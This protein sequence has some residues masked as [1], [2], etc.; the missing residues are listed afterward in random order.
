MFVSMSLLAAV[1]LFPLY[2]YCCYVVMSFRRIGCLLI[3]LCC[4]LQPVAMHS[5]DCYRYRQCFFI[6]FGMGMLVM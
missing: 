5:G 2:V 6:V 3:F 4:P 1:L